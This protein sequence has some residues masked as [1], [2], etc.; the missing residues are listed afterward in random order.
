ME[1]SKRVEAQRF[2]ENSLAEVL[3]M[4]DRARMRGADEKGREGFAREF[5]ETGEVDGVSSFATVRS[6]SPL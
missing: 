5:L 3:A 1:R 4:L 2:H 6:E